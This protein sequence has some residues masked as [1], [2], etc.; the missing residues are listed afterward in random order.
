MKATTDRQTKRTTETTTN[1]VI[2]PGVNV[3]SAVSSGEAALELSVSFV[4]SVVL[5][6]TEVA[7]GTDGEEMKT[8]VAEDEKL[9]EDSVILVGGE[10]AAVLVDDSDATVPVSAVRVTTSSVEASVETS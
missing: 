4:A 10:G 3:W 2:D 5:S 8:L 7:S 1:A 6:T 9:S